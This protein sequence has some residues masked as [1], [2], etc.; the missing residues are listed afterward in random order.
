MF[1]IRYCIRSEVGL[2]PQSVSQAMERHWQTLKTSLP[3][4]VAHMDMT[5]VT[6]H[7]QES[8]R[9]I[10]R[11]LGQLQPDG[12]DWKFAPIDGLGKPVGNAYP[13]YVSAQLVNGPAEI[14][15][16]QAFNLDKQQWTPN[17][18]TYA[19]HSGGG[20][21]K[22]N[23]FKFV[24]WDDV[25]SF[26]TVPLFC[27]DQPVSQEVHEA[28]LRCYRAQNREDVEAAFQ[29]MG[30]LKRFAPG[31]H[32]EPASFTRIRSV[33]GEYVGVVVLR[34]PHGKFTQ[35]VRC[36]CWR[37]AIVSAVVVFDRVELSH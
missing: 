23:R 3:R 16:R 11:L 7:L 5:V 33:F 2:T 22:S 29:D 18:R 13:S 28:M 9:S 8:H 10:G 25:R 19:A 36:G 30:I 34:H 27:A 4:G 15:E 32:A 21:F 20:N 17:A 12:D 31:Q 24:E 1:F 14:S 35:A 26:Y 6:D 37:Y